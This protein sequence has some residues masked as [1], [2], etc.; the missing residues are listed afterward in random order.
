M[1]AFTIRVD[2]NSGMFAALR[3]GDRIDVLWT[4]SARVTPDGI[5][6]EVT[7]QIESKL[8]VVAV[9]AKADGESVGALRT[10]TVAAT[11]EQVARLAQAQATGRL[12]MSMVG[13]YETS[14]IAEVADVDQCKLTGTNC[15][16]EKAPEVVERQ[17]CF[18]TQNKGGE[19][20]QIPVPCP[21]N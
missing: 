9:D 20:I 11:P 13:L 17:Q 10:L 12:A 16:V 8:E 15:P 6:G 5:S 18:I 2:N 7:R 3:A 14:E 1:R 21:T 19:R 4:G